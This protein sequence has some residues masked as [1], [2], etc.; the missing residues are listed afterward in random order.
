MVNVKQK[1]SGM[2]RTKSGAKH[3]A[4]MRSVIATLL[5]QQLPILSSL[6]ALRGQLSFQ[7]TYV[8][9]VD[10]SIHNQSQFPLHKS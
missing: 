1:V 9:A 4:R 6:T 8:V 7:T 10:F 2:F 3:F 5:K